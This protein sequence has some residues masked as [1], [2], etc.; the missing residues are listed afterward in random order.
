[1][2]KHSIHGG[3][4]EDAAYSLQVVNQNINIYLSVP[5]SL[6]RM[7]TEL[8]EETLDFEKGIKGS[9]LTEFSVP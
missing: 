6:M 8:T 4:W 7:M 3:C 5:L 1:M 9:P 2:L